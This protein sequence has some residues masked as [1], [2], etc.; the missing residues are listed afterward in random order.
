MKK[1]CTGL[2][3]RLFG[4]KYEPAIDE[5]LTPGDLSIDK[6]NLYSFTYTDNLCRVISAN[7]V[8]KYTY[9]GHVCV[10]CGDVVN[11]QEVDK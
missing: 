11:K 3:G 10:R 1:E 8:R 5:E 7:T 4:H 2:F 9:H 6:M